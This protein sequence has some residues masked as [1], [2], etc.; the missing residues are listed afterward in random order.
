ML[1]GIWAMVWPVLKVVLQIVALGIFFWQIWDT[2]PDLRKRRGFIKDVWSRVTPRVVLETIAMLGVVVALAVA[3]WHW[4]PFLQHGWLGWATG[5][6]GNALFSPIAHMSFSQYWGLRVL[7]ALCFGAIL[8]ML[9]FW[10][11]V[12]EKIFRAHRLEW[13]RIV[14][15]SIVFGLVHLIVGV[16][17][18]A[19][20]ILSVV[21]LFYGFVYR[22]A[23][24]QAWKRSLRLCDNYEDALRYCWDE[25]LI[26]STAYHTLYNSILIGLLIIMALISLAY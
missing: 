16:P 14:K 18:I 10:A 1:N 13:N 26:T 19:A 20:P 4:A 17:L 25:A 3:G 5:S 12:E 23:W 7:G 15:A 11:E 2:I 21:G 9:P 8:L 24:Y 22:R 6:E